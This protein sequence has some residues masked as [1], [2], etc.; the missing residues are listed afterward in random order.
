MMFAEISLYLFPNTLFVMK[1]FLLTLILL[2][3][4]AACGSQTKNKSL[5]PKIVEPVQYGYKIKAV[6]PHLATSYTQGLQFVD[7]QL[8]EGTGEWGTS[9]LQKVDLESGNAEV[10]ARLPK[11]EFGEGITVLGDK[12]YQLTWTNNTAHVYNLEGKEIKTFRYPGEGWGL[13]TDGEKL[14]MSDGSERIYKI[15]PETFKRE[16]AIAV[17]LRGEP[18][19]FLNELEWI[20]GKIWANVYTSDY[21]V[22][23]DPKTGIVEGVIDF[24]GL[25][26]QVEVKEDTDVFNGIAYDAAT[27]RIFVTGKLWNKLFEVELVKR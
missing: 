7:G 18:V 4:V 1:N 16:G 11:S 13:T 6:Y 9:V 24:R 17:T 23:I 12:V 27:K 3:A 10:L 25:I 21:V 8:W 14:Y 22:I 20:D 15:N 19:E 5:A 2:A 26:S